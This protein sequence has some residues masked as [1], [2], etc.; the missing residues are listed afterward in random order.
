MS[1][2]EDPGTQRTC[3]IVRGRLERGWLAWLDEAVVETDDD[4]TILWVSLVDQAALRGLL[5]QLWDLNLTVLSVNPAWVGR[6]SL[7][8]GRRWQ[9]KRHWR[10][11]D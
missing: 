5:S 10:S 7:V 8:G 3:I 6:S 1:G 11:K 9:H 4:V 2:Q